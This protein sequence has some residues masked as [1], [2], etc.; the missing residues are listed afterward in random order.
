M[1]IGEEEF[2]VLLLHHFSCNV[3][4]ANNKEAN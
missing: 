2:G 3:N 1:S 4:Q